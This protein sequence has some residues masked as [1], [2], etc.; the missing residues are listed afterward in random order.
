M[1][2]FDQL[3]VAVAVAKQQFGLLQK[4]YPDLTPTEYPDP[5]VNLFNCHA[6]VKPCLPRKVSIAYLVLSSPTGQV[7]IDSKQKDII[8]KFPAMVVDS[9]AKTKAMA[10][11]SRIKKSEGQD[12]ADSEVERLQTEFKQQV[13][14]LEYDETCQVEMRFKD[15][16]YELI[17]Q[18]QVDDLVDRR[19]TPQGKA[20]IRIVLGALSRFTETHHEH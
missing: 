19:L 7:G 12:K 11:M 5:K 4:K 3:Q 6:L 1:L 17:W 2:N 15:L 10:L 13:T 9:S 14:Q 20:S 8:R 18:L 16:N